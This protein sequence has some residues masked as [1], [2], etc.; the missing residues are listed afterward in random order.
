MKSK[1]VFAVM[2]TLCSAYG[3][4]VRTATEGFVTNRIAAAIAAL[5]A[6]DYSPTNAELRATI[7]AVAPSRTPMRPSLS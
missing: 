3:A 7:E 5:P 6:P 1:V 4:T 2:A